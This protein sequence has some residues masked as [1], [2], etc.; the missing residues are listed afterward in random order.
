M[1]TISSWK[2]II[3]ASLRRW[4]QEGGV[5]SEDTS[6]RNSWVK[7]EAPLYPATPLL[8]I[9]PRLLCLFLWAATGRASTRSVTFAFQQACCNRQ[10]KSVLCLSIPNDLKQQR[11]GMDPEDQQPSD[12]GSAN[13]HR[14]SRFLCSR[15]SKRVKERR[16]TPGKQGKGCLNFCQ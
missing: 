9:Q 6:L 5:R 12:H 15:C 13:S 10:G 7:H 14:S 3:S 11:Q 1:A 16:A 8:T 4:L 2:Y